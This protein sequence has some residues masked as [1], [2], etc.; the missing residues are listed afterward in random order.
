MKQLKLIAA[1]ILILNSFTSVSQNIQNLDTKYGFR[2]FK[3]ESSYDL[4]KSQLKPLDITKTGSKM[5][6]YEYTG[7]EYNEVFGYK[8]NKIS[9]YLSQ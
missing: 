6:Y 5:K 7:T 1:F 8:V 3:L 4:Y 2:K 9:L